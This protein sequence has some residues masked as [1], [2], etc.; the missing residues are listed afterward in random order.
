M[1]GREGPKQGNITDH[2]FVNKQ[3]KSTT[4]PQSSRNSIMSKVTEHNEYE[5]QLASV[6][7][8]SSVVIEQ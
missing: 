5:S 6:I 3:L 4:K 7:S 1:L 8:H 2:F